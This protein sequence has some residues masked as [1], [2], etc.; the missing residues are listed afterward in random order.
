LVIINILNLL[1]SFFLIV[2]IYNKKFKRKI[3]MK[4]AVI[5]LFFFNF[6]LIFKNFITNTVIGSVN[7]ILL[8][9]FMIVL[10]T[11]FSNR[12]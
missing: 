7:V 3:W 10:A 4:L 9:S 1:I 6:F 5:T 12:R 2:I 11:E 8:I